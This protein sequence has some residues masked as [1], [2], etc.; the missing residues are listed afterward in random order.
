MKRIKSLLYLGWFTFLH[1]LKK[2]LG[3]RRGI[4]SFE[5]NYFQEKLFPF[6][7]EADMAILESMKCTACMMCEDE[8]KLPFHYLP[9]SMLRDLP[10]FLQVKYHPQYGEEIY[11]PFGVDIP[12]IINFARRSSCSQKA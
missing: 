11:C 3:I 8:G 12:L 5:K 6:D 4:E 7:H 10:G 2:F 9:L 1:F